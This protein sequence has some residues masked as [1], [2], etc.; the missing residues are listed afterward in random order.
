MPADESGQESADVRLV[1]PPGTSNSAPFGERCLRRG[2]VS[3]DQ[4]VPRI[5][6]MSRLTRSR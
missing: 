4:R 1:E 2:H 5:T 6:Q 3:A